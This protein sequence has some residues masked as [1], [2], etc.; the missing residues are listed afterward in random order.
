M[1]LCSFRSHRKRILQQDWLSR[2]DTPSRS[3]SLS[4]TEV[5]AASQQGQRVR[6]S[7]I[8]VR[9]CM[10]RPIA[11]RRSQYSAF[12]SLSVGLLHVDDCTLAAALESPSDCDANNRHTRNS[13][14]FREQ[15]W[16]QYLYDVQHWQLQLH[17]R[18]N[19][20]PLQW[21]ALLGDPGSQGD[22]P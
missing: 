7:H 9:T 2:L 10:L 11:S 17:H 4:G 18:A 5:C 22:H 12:R 3:L 21:N 19:G 13:D 6:R 1:S 16:R 8:G 14:M 20:E 15:K